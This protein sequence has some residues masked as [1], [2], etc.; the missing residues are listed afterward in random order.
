MFCDLVGSTALSEQ[1]DPEEL[2]AVVRNYQATCA[3]IIARYEGHIAQYLGDGLLVYFGY[4]AAHEDDAARAVRAGLEIVAALQSRARQQAVDVSLPHGRGSDFHSLQARL[5]IHTGQ[6]VVGEMGS[7]SKRE[8][9]ALGDTPNIAARLQGLAEPDT[10]VLSPA[11]QR[12]IAGLFTCEDFGT[13]TLKG[14]STPIQ[15]YRVAGESGARDRFEVEASVGLTPL[16]GRDEE[17]ALLWRHWEQ[18]KEGEGR[19]VLLSGE[20]G[21]GKSRLLREFCDRVVREGASPIEFHCSP[22]HQN[23]AFYPVVTCLQRALQFTQEDSPEERLRKLE[24][25]VRH[26]MPLQPDTIPLLASL[27]SLP[28]PSGALPL[29]LSAQRQKQKTQEALVAWLLKETEHEAVFCSWEDLHWADP[30]TLEFLHLLIEQA[31]TSR[32]YMLLTFRPEFTA[33]WGARSHLSHLALSRLGRNQVARMV[34]NVTGGQRLPEEIVRQ[35]IAKTDG[36]PLFVE[37]L[38]K[39][40]IESIGSVK[41]PKRTPLQFAIPTT[42]HDSLMARLDR[43]G[44]AKEL[45]QLGAVIGREFSYELIHAV[46]PLEEEA[47][48]KA[49]SRVVEA[50][51]IYQQELLPQARYIFKHALVQDAAYQSLLKSTRQQHH[52]RIAQVLEDRFAEI[53]E[54]QPELLAHHYTEGGLIAQAIPYWQ[55]AGQKAAQRSANAEALSHLNKGLELLRILPNTPE[56]A[57]QE[58]TIQVALGVPLMATKGWSA[59]EVERAYVRARDLCEQLGETRQLF[60]VL[61]GLWECYDA[62]GNLVVARELGEQLLALAT[63]TADP[64]LLLVAHDVLA[65][66][67]YWVGEFVASLTHAEQ[68]IALYNHEQH[69]MLASLYGGYDP[70][71]ACLTW[72]TFSLWALGYPDRSSQK[73]GDIL[74]FSQELP[75]H[76]YSL[77]FAQTIATWFSQWRREGQ[78]VWEHIEATIS[79][80]TAQE[81]PLL[82]AW[83]MILQGWALAR[84]GAGKEGLASIR[85]GLALYRAMGGGLAQSYFLALLAETYGEMGQPEEGLAVLAEALSAVHSTGERF[86]EAELYRLKGELMLQQQSKVESQ[87]SKVS[88]TQHPTPS[89]EAEADAE[90]CFLKAIDIARQQQAKSLELRATMSLARLWQQQNKHHEARNTLAVIY[91]WFTEGFDTKDL[92]EATALLEELSH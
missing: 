65:D 50:E 62:Q 55:Q 82:A 87:K 68:G 29:N 52:Q 6:V 38:T 18:T 61:R 17:L 12:L 86:W 34:E 31:P 9:L 39:S 26:A 79:L 33:P 7:G 85:Q 36:V 83:A 77:A 67:L 10:V 51:L 90:A 47:L 59:P 22:Y 3:E 49:L 46:S 56:R 30:S 92:Q 15:V 24:E 60:S 35:I 2:R 4:P 27:L 28:H 8:Q 1:L 66:N 25:E 40:V 76:P 45:A 75:H 74:T 41:S 19:V 42:L 78:A 32:L 16:T 58:L 5:G 54:N 20:P 14:V 88:S 64:A 89:T 72:E 43:L 13:H 44:P 84:Q 37:E 73:L 23:S 69:H 57:Q 11:T 91:N 53:K 80:S 63:N 48:Q 71:I 70:G 81:F 21:I